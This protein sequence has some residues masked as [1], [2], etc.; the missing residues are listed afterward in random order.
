LGEVVLTKPFPSV[1]GELRCG[2]VS[3]RELADRFGTPLYVYD[4][5]YIAGR[6]R[7]FQRAFAGVNTLLAYSVKANGNLT[8]L[9][10]LRGLGCGADITSAGEFFRVAEAGIP[11]ED[12]VFAGVGKTDPEI[13]T[14]L[15]AGI[16]GFNVESAGEL[17]RID[18]IAE[19]RKTKAP[20]A[21]RVNPDVVAATPHEYTATG[22]AA[23]KFGVPLDKA[24]ALYRWAAGRA[25]LVPRGIDVHIGSQIVDVAPYVRTLDKVLDLVTELATEGVDLEYLDIGGGYGIR[26]HEEP[27]MD[28][29]QLAQEIVPRVMASG[30]RLVIEPGRSI[31][32]EAGV[33]LTRVQYVKR[34]GPRTFV[35]VDGGMSELLRPSH[36]GGYHA[37]ERA[38]RRRA[39]PTEMV[40]VV[41]PICESGDFLARDREMEVPEPGELLAVR[42]VGAYGFAMASN[43]NG[44]LRP[45]EVLVDS[46]GVQL[47]RRRET[48][49]DLVAPEENLDEGS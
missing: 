30:L 43:Y 2:S 17:Q 41:G 36:Y 10:R 24:A 47:V 23:A 6:V 18:A 45:A 46:E 5:D 16:Y 32:G 28:V 29:D 35:I 11:P 15:S 37:I 49:E 34:S 13:E 42:T 8:L 40:D 38:D 14:G 21:I 22:H 9:R 4:F 3:A 44:R 33:L 26:Y 25:H 20:F 12:V 31:V 27:G 39:R 48:L 7:T 1:D 19:S